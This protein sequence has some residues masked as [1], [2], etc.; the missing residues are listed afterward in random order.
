MLVAKITVTLKSGVL[1]PQGKAVHR[2]LES[3]GFKAISDVR[4]GKHIQVALNPGLSEG[5]AK[6]QVTEMCQKLLANEVIED[7]SF[8]LS[9]T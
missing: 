8:E 4:V 6:K 5:E 3:L 1:D 2:S 9:K 7:Y